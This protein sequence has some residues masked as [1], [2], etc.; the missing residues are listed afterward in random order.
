MRRETKVMRDA[1]KLAQMRATAREKAAIKEARLGKR[2]EDVTALIER[3]VTND[4]MAKIRKRGCLHV[5][6]FPEKVRK[7]R[8]AAN[9]PA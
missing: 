1:A 2:I 9:I 4:E 8:R 5:A 7:N 3:L 6:D